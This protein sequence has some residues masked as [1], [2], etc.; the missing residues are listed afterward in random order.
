V[1]PYQ[2]P[3]PGAP[4]APGQQP[5]G[6]PYGYSAAAPK[7][8]IPVILFIAL[9]IF[10]IV[11]GVVVWGLMTA[12]SSQDIQDIIDAGK[13]GQQATDTGLPRTDENGQT[14]QQ[15]PASTE[16]PS[17]SPEIP[18]DAPIPL[19]DGTIDGQWGKVAVMGPMMVVSQ[20]Q[21]VFMF[22]VGDSGAEPLNAYVQSNSGDVLDI[23]IGDAYNN[24]SL[25][26]F[27]S[28]ENGLLA[29]DEGGESQWIEGNP[30]WVRIGDFDGD[31]S[32]EVL[33]SEK[34]DAGRSLL[35]MWRYGL[36]ENG[37][38]LAQVAGGDV[39]YVYPSPVSADRD[40]LLGYS[41]G[42]VQVFGW[43][44]SDGLIIESEFAV[45]GDAPVYWVSG[46]TDGTIGISYGGATPYIEWF[47]PDGG[48]FVPMGLQRLPGT[49]NHAVF[50]GLF[51]EDG[52]LFL[53]DQ[54][55]DYFVY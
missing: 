51:D 52:W 33:F 38:M 1:P 27:V 13:G 5:Y 11:M 4:R 43:D 2:V 14:G 10:V 39:P 12:P 53:I 9:P 8:K 23:A 47:E 15:E 21:E 35:T 54:A 6:Q 46:D 28:F 36:T 7:K 55:G 18:A 17:G 19:F 30:S 25:M 34:D 48:M 22:E 3:P 24:G 45:G 41:R 20:E 31:G 16:Q 50:T 37:E 40:R 44:D 32:Q 29:I 42:G 49:G 26:A